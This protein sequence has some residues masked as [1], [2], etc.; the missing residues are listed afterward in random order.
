MT[1]SLDRQLDRLQKVGD[2]GRKVHSVPVAYSQTEDEAIRDYEAAHGA[3]N[4][5]D[6]VVLVLKFTGGNAGEEAEQPP[7]GRPS[8]TVIAVKR[9]VRAQR[10]PKPEGRVRGGTTCEQPPEEK[11]GKRDPYNWRFDDKRRMPSQIA[12]DWE[13]P[14]A[15]YDDDDAL[16]KYAVKLSRRSSL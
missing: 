15:H 14:G 4:E 13:A 11:D 16:R 10:P 1:A 8:P 9:K 2:G 7:E 3:I 5:G 12:P 6:L